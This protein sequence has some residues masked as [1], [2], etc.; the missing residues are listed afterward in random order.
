MISLC[1]DSYKAGF[2]VFGT[3][4]SADTAENAEVVRQLVREYPDTEHFPALSN[5]YKSFYYPDDLGKYLALRGVETKI[6][7]HSGRVL[8]N[9]EYQ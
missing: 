4:H 9:G 7:A 5:G 8:I 2:R 3:H 6:L 1:A